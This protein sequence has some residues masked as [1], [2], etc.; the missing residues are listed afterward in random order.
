MAQMVKRLPAMQET[1]VWSLGWEDSLET[2][3]ATH[4]STLAWKIGRLLSP[5]GRKELDM[6]EQLHLHFSEVKSLTNSPRGLWEEV[7]RCHLCY[8]PRKTPFQSGPGHWRAPGEKGT[9]ESPM[10]KCFERN[11]DRWAEKIQNNNYRYGGFPGGWDGKES[12]CNLGD[13]G[14]IPG[15]EDPLE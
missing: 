11:I 12:A 5:W 9:D 4:S 3:I 2:E 1:R 10:L 6:T 7:A 13:P 14:L 15:W 8:S